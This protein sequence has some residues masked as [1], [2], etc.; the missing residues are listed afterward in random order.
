M[1]EL[2]GGGGKIGVFKKNNINKVHSSIDLNIRAL[3]AK[4]FNK[5]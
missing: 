4:E 2:G 5:T 3:R 1:F